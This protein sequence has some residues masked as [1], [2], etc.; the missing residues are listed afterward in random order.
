MYTMERIALTLGFA[1]IATNLGGCGAI[2][3]AIDAIDEANSGDGGFFD[4]SGSGLTYDASI[5]T[6]SGQQ[7]TLVSEMPTTA[8]ASYTGDYSY[9]TTDFVNGRFGTARLD[10]DFA[11]GTVLL[12]DNGRSFLPFNGL[13]NGSEIQNDLGANDSG[14][15]MNGQFYGSAA[16]TVGVKFED[17]NDGAT[18]SRGGFIGSQ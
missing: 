12:T 6:I 15:S 10:A 18:G 9:H 13:I 14:R 4:L 16:E 8:T 5:N 7:P 11:A 17:T 2:Q 3:D 1:L